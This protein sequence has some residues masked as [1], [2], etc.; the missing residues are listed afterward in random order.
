VNPTQ[1]LQ[2][3]K[4]F[5]VKLEHYLFGRKSKKKKIKTNDLVHIGR[6]SFS[7]DIQKLPVCKYIFQKF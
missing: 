3:F 6:P 1:K 4:Q 5:L 7:Y 2:N